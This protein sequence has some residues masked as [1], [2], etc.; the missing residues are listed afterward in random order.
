MDTVKIL[1]L[2]SSGECRSLRVGMASVP[3]CVK[4]WQRRR[5]KTSASESVSGWPL[6]NLSHLAVSTPNCVNITDT[7]TRA[8]K[9]P[10]A[11]P[12]DYPCYRTNKFKSNPFQS[13]IF[14]AGSQRQQRRSLPVGPPTLAKGRHPRPFFH[15]CPLNY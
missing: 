12:N 15:M 14:K 13:C 7:R 3:R 11:H 5:T 2:L 1:L 9:H 8:S 4:W 6:G 10:I